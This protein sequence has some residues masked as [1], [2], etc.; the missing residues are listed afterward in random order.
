MDD[1]IRA[2]I[3]GLVEGFTEFLPVSSTGHLILVKNI[4][5][6]SN[7]AN[8]KLADTFIVFIQLGAILAVLWLYWQRFLALI[9]GVVKDSEMATG[10]VAYEGIKK[11]ALACLPAFILGPF[12]DDYLEA[13]L[14]YPLPVAFALAFGGVVMLYIEARKHSCSTSKI[15][16]ISLKQ[17]FGIGLFQCLALWPGMSRSGSTIVGGLLMGLERSVAAEFSFIVAVPIMG[18]ASCFKILKNYSSFDIS[19]IWLFAVGF[20]FAFFSA[21]VAIKFML[22]LLKKYTFRPYAYYRIVLAFVI[23]Y[24]W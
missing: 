16:D 22:H 2:A 21:L 4:L 17:A 12:L 6:F 15:S 20:V 5:E 10:F 14:F 7:A 1:L 23:F 11:I 9:P 19:S 18:A 3:L 24:F 8:A 13:K